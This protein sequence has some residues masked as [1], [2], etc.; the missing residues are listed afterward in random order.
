MTLKTQNKLPIYKAEQTLLVPVQ[1][2][3]IMLK[4]PNNL[5]QLRVY[6][7]L[8]FKY[9]RKIV[10][11]KKIAKAIANDLNIRSVNTLKKHIGDLVDQ[12]W[13][14]FDM[15]GNLYIRSLIYIFNHCNL[16]SQVCVPVTSKD[17]KTFRDFAGGAVIGYWVKRQEWRRN[18]GGL[19]RRSHKQP[20]FQSPPVPIG[21]SNDLI[22]KILGVSKTKACVLKREAH[23][24]SYLAVQHRYTYIGTINH[25]V[26]KYG[27]P[28]SEIIGGPI[29]IRRKKVYQQ[30]FDLISPRIHYKVN[31]RIK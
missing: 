19:S 27:K 24:C 22:A 23:K 18:P 3:S 21:L 4:N 15:S 6:L 5:N 12:G 8:K 25:V 28:I 26:S 1:L 16:K 9:G 30:N 13:L 14:G 29:V 20:G 11:F 2:I 10:G 31:K 7:W 17:F